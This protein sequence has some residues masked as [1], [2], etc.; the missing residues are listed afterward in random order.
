MTPVKPT[1]SE[2]LPV[3]IE[4]AKSIINTTTSPVLDEAKSIVSPKSASGN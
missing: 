3:V 4:E 2:T 1:V